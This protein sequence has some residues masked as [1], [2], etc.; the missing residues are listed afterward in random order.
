MLNISKR[1]KWLDNE[2]DVYRFTKK[3]RGNFLN[4]WFPD[5]ITYHT[6]KLKNK[7]HHKNM[8]S[9]DK[10]WTLKKV[11][12]A[13][14]NHLYGERYNPVYFAINCD[15]YR[16]TKENK[17]LYTMCGRIKSIDDS[18]YGIWWVDK[19]LEFLYEKRLEMMRWVD[20]VKELNGE[21]FFEKAISLGADGE[22]KDYN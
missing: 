19:T 10:L 1:R 13:S 9:N 15:F 12:S 11:D 6:L 7:V 21:A 20:S 5:E 14:C 22:Y 2:Y 18:S 16:S 17:V 8:L 4:V 3:E